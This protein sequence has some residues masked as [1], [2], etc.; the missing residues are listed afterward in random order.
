MSERIV[1][2]CG[3]QL[4][5]DPER[6]DGVLRLDFVTALFDTC[7]QLKTQGHEVI[8]VLSGAVAAGKKIKEIQTKQARAS[9]GQLMINRELDQFAR[10]IDLSLLLLTKFDITERDRHTTLVKTIDELLNTKFIPVLNENDATTAEGTNDFPDNDHL[11]AIIA[12]TTQA[13][14]VL[15]C[16][17]VEG[18][19]SAHP[20]TAGAQLFDEIENVN[21]ELLKM[22]QG[23]KSQLGRGG[24]TGKLKA[25]RLATSAGIQ[26]HIISGAMVTSIPQLL[27]G[28]TK[29]GTVCKARTR[30]S[31]ELSI[32][33]RWLLSAKISDGSIVL[34]TGAAAAVKKRKSLLAVGVKTIYGQFAPGDSVEILDAQKETIAIGLANLSSEEL[35]TALRSGEKP[36]DTDVVHANNLILL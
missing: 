17:D 26:T 34:D 25:A 28:S 36:F 9:I 32:R 23:G 15:L 20:A 30:R 8:L 3:S 29:F 16:T 7:Q 21:L 35:Q 14:R 6:T 33:D 1:I 13:D 27:D 11:A 19:F 31:T 2:K 5:I 22:T 18:V 4:V 12:I 24:M 10:Q